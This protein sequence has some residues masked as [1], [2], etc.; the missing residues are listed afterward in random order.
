MMVGL[1]GLLAASAL[2]DL[3]DDADDTGADP[4][5]SDG[6]DSHDHGHPAGHPPDDDS[7][8][9]RGTPLE[10]IDLHPAAHQP[11]APAPIPAR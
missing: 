2:L 6:A 3:H 4:H 5:G 7:D 1:M 8:H 10:G 11:D 9:H